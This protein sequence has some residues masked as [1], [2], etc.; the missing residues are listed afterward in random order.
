MTQQFMASNIFTT[1]GGKASRTKNVISVFAATLLAVLVSLILAPKAHATSYNVTP[2]SDCSLVQAL[3]AAATD[4]A[5][6]TCAAGDG[7]DTINVGQGT[8]TLAADLGAIVTSGN[9]S[10]IGEDASNTIIDGAGFSGITFAAQGDY[11]IENLTFTGFISTDLGST[12]FINGGGNVTANKLIVR[13][14]TCTAAIPVCA[15]ALTY[16]TDDISTTISNSTFYQN[17]AFFLFANVR[18]PGE[19]ASGSSTMNIFNN[20]IF[21]NTSGIVN[22]ANS[23][24]N[25]GTA[26]TNFYNNTVAQN[27]PYAEFADLMFVLNVG[28]SPSYYSSE[29][30]LRNNVLTGNTNLAG[31]DANCSSYVGENGSLTSD[32]GNISDD[33]TCNTIFTS[34]N[35]K[36][37]TDPLLDSY[38]QIG[39]TFV[40]PLQA[41]SP[42]LENAVAGAPATP[43]VDQRGVTRPQSA[44]ADSGAFEY[45]APVPPP[46]PSP[47]ELAP[48]GW[49]TRLPVLLATLFVL[50]GLT[51]VGY[52]LKKN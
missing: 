28:E 1:L 52:A 36:N 39:S 32:G 23:D 47:G 11:L 5:V 18:A 9:I 43:G 29:L 6:G 26:V 31:A 14:N 16:F 20:T 33:A 46:S 35:D 12:L 45:V 13:Q 50:A 4:I 3:E 7:D 42:A 49:D 34:S 40:M 15:I 51:G 19:L 37:S 24:P 48:T 17:T 44:I 2:T 25:P 41:A 30:N 38:Q 21:D 10:V 8:Y 22:T 27:S